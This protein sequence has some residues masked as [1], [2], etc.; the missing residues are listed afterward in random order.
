MAEFLGSPLVSVVFLL[1]LTAT[2]V[3]VGIYAIGKVRAG[4]K[5]QEPDASAWLTKF[6]ELHVQGELSDEEFRTIKAMLA[7]RLQR[8]LNDT[9]KSA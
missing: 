5:R 4:L 9:E 3:A 6:Q 8:E 7:K 1:A 2:L